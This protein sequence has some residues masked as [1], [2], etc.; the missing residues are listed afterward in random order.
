[1]IVVLKP[2]CTEDDFNRVIKKIEDL[3]LAVHISK[4]KERTIIGVV[5]EDAILHSQSLESL[6]SVEKIVPILKPYKLVS[7]EFKKD[8]TIINL[9]GVEIGGNRIQVIAGPCAVEGRE[10]LLDVAQ[11]IEKTG[12]KFL[13][14]GA[15]K[16]RTSPY[17]FQGLG[18]EGLRYLAEARKST[19]LMVVTELMDPRDIDMVCE[20]ADIIQIGTRNMQNFRLLKEV[21][22]IKKPVI[23]KRGFSSTILELLMSA[24]YIASQGNKQIILCERGIRTFETSTRNTLDISAIPIIKELS[25][26]PII[27]DPSH[28]VGKWNLVGPVSRAAI[29]AGA[30]GLMIEVHPSPQDALSDG[31]QSLKPDRFK[32]LMNDLRNI[33]N[34]VGRSL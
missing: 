23:L 1:M 16:P 31:P 26:L 30:D 28:A 7:R 18:E 17:S 33:A 14:G 21:G 10:M 19:G 2:T 6:P 8:N 22:T 13:R 20:Y 12:T 27:I 15:F 24:E 4:G 32:N 3:G 34:A 25:H 11:S 29:A 5:G 9:N